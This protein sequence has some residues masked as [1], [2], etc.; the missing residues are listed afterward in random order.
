MLSARWA[1]TML[2]IEGNGL[3]H[4]SA[5]WFAMTV[6]FDTFGSKKSAYAIEK[7]VIARSRRR[8]G[9]P[10]PIPPLNDNLFYHTVPSKTRKIPGIAVG[11]FPSR[12]F[13]KKRGRK[14]NL[15]KGIAAHGFRILYIF[16]LIPLFEYLITVF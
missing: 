2:R 14:E 10:H 8:R 7:Y 9:N 1:D 3:P 11:D 12:D 13:G 15:C 16:I 4:Q 6:V 5:D